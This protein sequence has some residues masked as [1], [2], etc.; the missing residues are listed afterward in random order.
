M[1]R[2]I[3][4]KQALSAVTFWRCQ[5]NEV[6][7]SEIKGFQWWC[8]KRKGYGHVNQSAPTA[9]VRGETFLEDTATKTLELGKLGFC[10]LVFKLY[11]LR[12]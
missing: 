2:C 4:V 10:S 9:I 12:R 1:L 11:V 5:E 7:I 6:C 3:S 8:A